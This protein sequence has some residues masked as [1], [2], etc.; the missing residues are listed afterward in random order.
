MINMT[1]TKDSD[2]HHQDLTELDLTLNTYKL[3]NVEYFM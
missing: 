3:Q 2:V 1:M